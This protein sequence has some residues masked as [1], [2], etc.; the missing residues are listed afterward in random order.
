MA[1]K[2]DYKRLWRNT[3][4][5]NIILAN[6]LT[7]ANNRIDELQDIIIKIKNGSLDLKDVTEFYKHE[8]TSDNLVESVR[9]VEENK[10]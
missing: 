6:N 2:T 8:K 7:S 3:S 9:I 4:R 1:N 10:K 5:Q